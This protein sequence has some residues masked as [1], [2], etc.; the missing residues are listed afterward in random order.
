MKELK[1]V[2]K[3]K[4]ITISDNSGIADSFFSRARGLMFS[5]P[6]DLVLVSPVESIKHSSIHML[7][8]RFPIDILWLDSEKRVVDIGKRILPFNI[9]NRKTHKIHKLRMFI[10]FIN[11]FFY[12]IWILTS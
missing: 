7:F 8:M 3:D 9:S 6:K 4:E 2:N 5:Q 10:E 12:Y 11:S 1:I